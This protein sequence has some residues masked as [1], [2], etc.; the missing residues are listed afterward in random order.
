MRFLF[1]GGP[2]HGRVSEV[3]PS[4]PTVEVYKYI[5]PKLSS[6]PD[7]SDSVALDRYVYVRTQVRNSATDD[8]AIVY[9]YS[10]KQYEWQKV[11]NMAKRY[12][13]VMKSWQLDLT[14][15]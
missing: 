13:L 6:V 3:P 4:S 11:L 1:Y 2:Y 12:R 7:P 14:A 9:I 5:P 15:R 8:N 10:D